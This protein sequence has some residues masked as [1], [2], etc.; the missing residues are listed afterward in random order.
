MKNLLYI[1]LLCTIPAQA[2]PKSAQVRTYLGDYRYENDRPTGPVKFIFRKA[3]IQRDGDGSQTYKEILPDQTYY[4]DA[5]NA[6]RLLAIQVKGATIQPE[7][8]KA[9]EKGAGFVESTT[10]DPV[11]PRSALEV[12]NNLPTTLPDSAELAERLDNTQ[13]IIDGWT[14]RMWQSAKPVWRFFMYLFGLIIPLLICFGGVCRYVAKSSAQESAVN[15][16]GTPIIGRW[17][18]SIHQKSAGMLLLTTW[19]VVIVLLINAFLW[20]VWFK[21][22]I[23]WM[24][25]IWFFILWIAEMFTGWIVPNVRVVGGRQDVSGNFPPLTPGR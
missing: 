13:V 20:L 12:S 8:G 10:G 25:P 22:S 3:V 17:M 18:L 9:A 11:R 21:I 1:L 19:V 2:Q 24:V 14:A 5:D 15:L 23:W 4:S 6:G 7:G 16:Y